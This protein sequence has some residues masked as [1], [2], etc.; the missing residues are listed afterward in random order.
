MLNIYSNKRTPHLQSY[1]SLTIASLL[2]L[3]SLSAGA[4][5]KLFKSNQGVVIYGFDPVAYFTLGKA[6]EGSKDISVEFLGGTWRFVSE[7][8]RELFL[9]DPEKYIPQYGGHCAWGIVRDDGHVETEPNSWRIVDGKLYL[10]RNHAAN[11]RWD[12]KNPKTQSANREWEENK[13][14]LLQQ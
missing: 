2:L 3:L 11:S 10:F 14:I 1:L 7:A 4:D 9:A 13:A 12:I 5:H 8:N 6:R